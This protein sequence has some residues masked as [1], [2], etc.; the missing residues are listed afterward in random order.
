MA[1]TK[2]RLGQGGAQCFSAL[3]IQQSLSLSTLSLSILSKNSSVSTST[4][5]LKSKPNPIYITM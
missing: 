4:K 1:T 2:L 3:A 5:P